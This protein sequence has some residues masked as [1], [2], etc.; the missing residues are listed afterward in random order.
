[1]ENRFTSQDFI[2]EAGIAGLI[3][4]APAV[5]Y[6]GAGYLTG[7]STSMLIKALTFVLWVG[8]FVGCIWLLKLMMKNFATKFGA[9]R[10]SVRNFGY[11]VSGLSA[12][13]CSA[14]QLALTLASSEKLQETIDIMMEQYSTILDSNSMSMMESMMGNLPTITFCWSLFYCFIFGVVVTLC[15]LNGIAPQDPFERQ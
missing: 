10:K 14:A 13:V 3:V 12:I 6:I 1:M 9:E 11:A 5:A 8:K 2:Q 15:V 7:D 4:A